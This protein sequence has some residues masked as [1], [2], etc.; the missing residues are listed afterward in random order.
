MNV[1]EIEFTTGYPNAP[2]VPKDLCEA[3]ILRASE[4]YL[5]PE[6]EQLNSKGSLLINAAEVKERN[7]KIQR[8]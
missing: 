1:I 2:S 7:Y 5:H 4:A 8:F 3:I 6:N